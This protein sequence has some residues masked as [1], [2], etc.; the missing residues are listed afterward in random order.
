MSIPRFLTPN[1]HGLLDY[2]AALALIMFPYFLG[3]SGLPLW[4]SI[5]GGVLLIAYSLIT[6]YALGAVRILSFKAHLVL[7][8]SAAAAFVAAPLTF[9]WSGLVMGYYFFM[10]A[11]VSIVVALSRSQDSESAPE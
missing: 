2:A 10:A 11:G 3:F 1:L 5:A 8:L 7:D 9:G 6:D 4:L